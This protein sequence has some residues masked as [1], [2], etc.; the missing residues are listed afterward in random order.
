[1]PAE[2]IIPLRLPRK[3]YIRGCLPSLGLFRDNDWTTDARCIFS[4]M[5]VR[6]KQPVME[7]HVGTRDLE[8]W[9]D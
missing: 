7:H 6:M 5:T 3:P 9:L 2:S 1:M 4:M 8:R